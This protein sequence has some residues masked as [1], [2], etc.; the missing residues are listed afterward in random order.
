[1][2]PINSLF[3]LDKRI[4]VPLDNIKP[5]KENELDLV[6]ALNEYAKSNRIETRLVNGS[7]IDAASSFDNLL[8]AGL[9]VANH[10]A[11]KLPNFEGT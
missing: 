1:V 11:N 6:D 10:G 5:N 3:I 9:L 8:N 2:S 4:L 7:W